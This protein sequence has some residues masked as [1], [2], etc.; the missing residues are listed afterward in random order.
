MLF[1][2]LNSCAQFLWVFAVKTNAQL[3]NDFTRFDQ[4]ARGNQGIAT[5]IELDAAVRAETAM[6]IG[7]VQLVTLVAPYHRHCWLALEVAARI[8][9]FDPLKDLRHVAV[10]GTCIADD[11]AAK[12]PWNAR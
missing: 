2:F 11:A 3:H 5:L 8:Q 9:H 12:S 6:A 10:M 1:I 4:C 7:Q